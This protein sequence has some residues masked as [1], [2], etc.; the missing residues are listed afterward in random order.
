M[1]NLYHLH[2]E[3]RP[4]PPLHGTILHLRDLTRSEIRDLNL[5]TAQGACLFGFVVWESSDCA[6]HNDNRF[7]T[8]L[9]A[10]LNWP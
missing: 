6:S 8:L 9:L 2:L 3:P 4:A 1:L 10:A 5:R 7:I